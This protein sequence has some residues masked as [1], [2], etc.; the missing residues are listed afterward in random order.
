MNRLGLANWLVHES[1]PLT[2]R[3]WVNRA[4]ERFFGTGLVKTSE[5][6]GSQAEFPS[7]LDLL[8]WLAAEFMKPTMLPSVAGEPAK[9]WDMKAMHRLIVTSATYRQSSRVTPELYARDPFNRLLA[10]GP[11]H[12]A[13]QRYMGDGGRLYR[14]RSKSQ[15]PQIDGSTF[16]QSKEARSPGELVRC[17]IVASDGYDLIAR[18]TSELEKKV[19]IRVLG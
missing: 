9:A 10:R 8:D 1:N 13:L 6:L 17:T 3:V 11:R 19:G 15:A 18:P 2:A 14:G 4:W 16:V 12:R 5:N 7:H